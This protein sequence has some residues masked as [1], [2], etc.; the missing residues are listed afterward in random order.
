MTNVEH[1]LGLTRQALDEFESVPL[2]ASLR[3]ALRIAR[4]SLDSRAVMQLRRAFGIQ[5][6]RGYL[7]E[8]QADLRQRRTPT[9]LAVLNAEAP[10]RSRRS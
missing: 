1:M 3:R 6:C 7:G 5:R 10:Q 4:L 2:A 9:R 8:R